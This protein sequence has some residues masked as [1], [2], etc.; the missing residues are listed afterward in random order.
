M[1]AAKA[2]GILFIVSGML[3]AL[4]GTITY[5]VISTE[6]DDCIYTTARIVRIDQKATGDPEIPF[7]YTT[8]VKLKV[9]GEEITTELNTYSSRFNIGQEIDIYYF[10]NDIRMVYENRSEVF[11]LIFAIIGA[12]FTAIGAVFIYK[13]KCFTKE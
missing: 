8:H 5:V 10:E 7:E 1:K 6:K 11:Y 9:N 3:F 12:I 13:S 4:L 2:I